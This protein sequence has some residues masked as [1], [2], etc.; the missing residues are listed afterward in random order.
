[1]LNPPKKTPRGFLLRLFFSILLTFPKAHVETLLRFC[2]AFQ[3]CL[4]AQF[5]SPSQLLKLLCWIFKNRAKQQVFIDSWGFCYF[6]YSTKFGCFFGWMFFF[7]ITQVQPT[8]LFYDKTLL[9]SIKF[10]GWIVLLIMEIGLWTM[11][12]ELFQASIMFPKSTFNR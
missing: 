7:E 8:K 10:P 6:Q 9:F 4:V 12:R 5:L 1:M 2:Q 3:G 11:L